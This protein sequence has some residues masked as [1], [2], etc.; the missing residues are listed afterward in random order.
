M[1]PQGNGTVYIGQ[2]DMLKLF[3]VCTKKFCPN[4]DM[5][6]ECQIVHS[7]GEEKI[8]IFDDLLH[9]WWLWFRLSTVFRRFGV[10][11]H[12]TELWELFL[13]EQ[14]RLSAYL[15]RW[16]RIAEQSKK[17]SNLGFLT[18]YRI[19]VYDFFSGSREWKSDLWKGVWRSSTWYASW[20]K[21][22]GDNWAHPRRRCNVR[23]R[24]KSDWQSWQ[25]RR[26]DI[27]YWY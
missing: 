21:Y 25:I 20:Q 3:E 2:T 10:K 17:P 6:F 16:A 5:E 1:I 11:S 7:C 26:S 27:F 9:S 13:E 12:R 18:Y 24:N 14:W 22:R 19:T 15:L 4:I 23:I 8:A